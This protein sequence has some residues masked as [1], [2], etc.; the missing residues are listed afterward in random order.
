MY[1]ENIIEKGIV[2]S[3][4]DGYAEIAL[5]QTGSCK[6]CSAKIFCKPSGKTDTKILEVSDP[7]G[8]KPGD[9]VQIQID[10]SDVL[11]ASVLLYGVPLLL[12]V[13]GIIVG[14]SLFPRTLIPELLSFLFG[15]GLTTLYISGLFLIKKIKHTKPNLPQIT[16]V[17]RP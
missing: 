8:V 6:E 7:F 12:I 4:K 15:L 13:F 5:M 17:K 10:G 14:M 2:L 3:T 9:E 1:N 16:F 11:K